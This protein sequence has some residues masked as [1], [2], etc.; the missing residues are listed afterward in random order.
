MPDGVREVK[1]V[2]FRPIAALDVCVLSPY[3]IGIHGG[4]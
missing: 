2:P 3:V 1:G 4:F